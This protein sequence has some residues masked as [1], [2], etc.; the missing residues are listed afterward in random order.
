MEN[1]IKESI[2]LS[3]FWEGELKLNPEIDVVAPKIIRRSFYI[4]LSWN[5]Q[6]KDLQWPSEQQE[7]SAV[8]RP[9][10][11]QNFRD[12]ERKFS[13]GVI[14]YHKDI[15]LQKKPGMREFLVFEGSNFKGEGSGESYGCTSRCRTVGW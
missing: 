10:Q 6:I 3:G 7:L 1:I 13:E 5:M 2:A 14:T 15:A 11:N 4:P 8:T 9:L 12:K